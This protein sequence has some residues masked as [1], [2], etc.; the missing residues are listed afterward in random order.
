M[1]LLPRFLSSVY[2]AMILTDF[3][4]ILKKLYG[5]NSLGVYTIYLFYLFVVV[6][7]A[8]FFRAAAVHMEVPRLGIQ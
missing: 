3:K 1:A 6:V 5:T 8:F 7:V 2:S 4:N